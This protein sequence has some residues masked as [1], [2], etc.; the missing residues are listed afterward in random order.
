VGGI[1]SS[2][3]LRNHVSDLADSPQ[4]MRTNWSWQKTLIV[5]LSPYTQ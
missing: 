2:C 1:G 4:T 5:N 3:S